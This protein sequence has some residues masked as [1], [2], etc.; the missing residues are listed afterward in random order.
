[1]QWILLTSR[2]RRSFRFEAKRCETEA[3]IFFASKRKNRMFFRNVRFKRNPKFHMRNE[4]M[5]KKTN[6]NDLK[7]N[8][9]QPQAWHGLPVQVVLSHLLFRLSSA[10]LPWL[11]CPVCTVPAVLSRLSCLRLSSFWL[12]CHG[13]PVQV[14]LSQ[15]PCPDYATPAVL[16]RL[17]CL[18]CPCQVVRSRLSRPRLSCPGHEHK[19]GYTVEQTSNNICGASLAVLVISDLRF[20]RRFC[21]P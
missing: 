14:I 1:L 18:G 5:R 3:K 21:K 4:T 7:R 19:H 20:L 8:I 2:V 12:S 17:S 13:C 15:L 10:V 9:P 16:S 6:R 11:S